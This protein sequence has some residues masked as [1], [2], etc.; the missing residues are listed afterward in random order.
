MRASTFEHEKSGTESAA[1]SYPPTRVP[2]RS[3]QPQ[4]NRK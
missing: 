2:D 1:F 4:T 3:P